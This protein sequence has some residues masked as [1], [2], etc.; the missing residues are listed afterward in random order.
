M[1]EE[2]QE[3]HTSEE[4]VEVGDR[5]L[6]EGHYGTVRYTGKVPP[7]EG[8][9]LG[10]EWDNSERGKHDGSHNGKRY[11]QCSSPTGGSF[12]RPKKAD[13]GIVFLQAVS[14]RYIPENLET[15]DVDNSLAVSCKAVEMVGAEK[16]SRLQSSFENLKSVAVHGMRISR[17]GDEKIAERMPNVRDLDIS[18]NLLPSWQE[19]SRVTHD[20]KYLK[21]LDVSENRLALPNDLSS[22]S[23]AFCAVEELFINR[24]N[25]TWPELL[26]IARMLPKLKKVHACFNRISHLTR[27][28]DGIF[29]DLDLLNLEGNQV[30][31][32]QD[33]LQLGHLPG[34]QV[35]ILNAN[36]I[37]SVHFDDATSAE[38]TQLFTSLKSLS[39]HN[40]QIASWQ[41]VNEMNKLQRLEE[42]NLKRNPVV[43]D[44][45][46]ST[47]RGLMIAKLGLLSHCNHSAVSDA[48]RRGSEIDYLKKYHQEW[49]QSGGGKTPPQP[50][51][52]DFVDNHPR[53]AALVTVYGA[54][55]V[56]DDDVGKPGAL[57]SSL[58]VLTLTCP[59][60]DDKKTI[61]KKLPATM[62]VTKV[63]G[64][65]QKLFKVDVA[66]QQLF[67]ISQKLPDQEIPL[68]NDLR[69]LTFFG[70]ESGDTIIVKW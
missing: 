51:K 43:Q 39:L 65:I 15:G 24:C 56:T 17:A 53:Y 64:M 42:L 48:E 37:P 40:N 54:P 26:K 23:S 69:Q 2:G 7:T 1:P 34:L 31:S 28:E 66:D 18:K 4:N 32:W 59:Q 46:P 35:L 19:L 29:Q 50:L 11:F 10:I 30:T 36:N 52:Q 55:E 33:V 67:Y 14:S 13:T 9:W 41:S 47:V 20:M 62:D 63:K 38:K 45:K 21:R 25:I 44:E 70:V 68:D 22:L 12:L 5:I 49:L 27:P 8:Q 60:R 3:K 58:L 16:I 6:S 61:K 57:K